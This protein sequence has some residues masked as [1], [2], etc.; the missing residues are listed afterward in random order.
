MNERTLAAFEEHPHLQIRPNFHH[1]TITKLDMTH[2][3]THH[4]K[5]THPINNEILE[6]IT[7]DN[8]LPTLVELDYCTNNGHHHANHLDRTP[9]STNNLNLK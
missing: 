3:L 5:L 8:L 7:H 6:N 9:L 2:Q 1:H 4:K